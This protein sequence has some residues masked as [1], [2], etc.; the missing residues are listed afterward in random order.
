[1]S[2][3]IWFGGLA[4]GIAA[5]VASPTHGQDAQRQLNLAQSALRS[6]DYLEAFVKLKPLADAGDPDA[7]RLLADMYAWGLGVPKSPADAE[8]LR[9]LANQSRPLTLPLPSGRERPS[10]E[11]AAGLA[12]FSAHDYSQAF[13]KL[14]PGAEGGDP[15]A[16]IRL[17]DMFAVGLGVQ[18]SL[19]EARRLYRMAQ[20]NPD[21]LPALVQAANTRLANL[22]SD[23]EPKEPILADAEGSIP[24]PVATQVSKSPPASSRPVQ[25]DRARTNWKKVALGAL[26]VV[27]IA[28]VVVA[29]ANS[30]GG[31]G[32]GAYAPSSDYVWHWDQFMDQRGLYEWRCR[33]V[34]TGQFAD[35]YHCA[36]QLQFDNTWPGPY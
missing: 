24:P 29:A 25:P 30:G 21:A 6:H 22:P 18:T 9:S 8:R 17:G 7:Q 10:N 16:Q 32:G 2:S 20:S 4:G 11:V 12:A 5:A 23:R 1:M 26:A 28:A 3:A 14:K 13:V 34:Q 36:G 15:Q 27:A 35:N 31:G 33:G 19:V